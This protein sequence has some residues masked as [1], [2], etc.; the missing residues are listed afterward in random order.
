MFLSL[1]I[2]YHDIRENTVLS[3]VHGVE[4]RNVMDTQT[5]EDIGKNQRK[6]IWNVFFNNIV[7]T[8]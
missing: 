5:F 7:D 3:P 8:G 4:M 6:A 1:E 2:S